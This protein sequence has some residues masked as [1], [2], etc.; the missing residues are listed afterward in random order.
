MENNSQVDPRNKLNAL[1]GKEWIRFTKSWFIADGKASEISHEI[2][3]HPAS[4]PPAMIQ[5]FIEFFTKPG[6][7]VID[8]FLGTGSTMVACD[9]CQREGVG[10]ELYEKYVDTAKSRT[11]AE[12]YQGDAR[13]IIYE[14]IHK[15]E[16]FSLCITSPP[17]WRILT[18][19]KDY[20][21][22]ARKKKGLD[23]QYGKN[24]KDLGLISERE[25][26]LC[27]LVQI[28]F[29]I[30]E[31][32]V[33]KGHLII[34]VQNVREKGELFPLAF[35]LALRLRSEFKF[36]GEKIWLQNQKVLRPYGMPYSFVP[37]IHHHY[38]LIFQKP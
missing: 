30:K 6:E 8:P 22:K 18:K 37:N 29:Q 24:P 38:C 27:E 1:T 12:I 33:D 32:L 34:F 25:N 7:K 9:Q 11:S 36:L 20:N 10:I 2:E 28:F 13:E 21:Q 17:Y 5:E 26:F 31:L 19:R 35:E 3:L 14:L 16:K 15:G 4:F 23:L